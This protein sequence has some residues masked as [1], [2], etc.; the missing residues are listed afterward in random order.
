MSFPSL[1]VSYESTPQTVSYPSPSQEAI[2]GY[3]GS[4][5]D[6]A[7][8]S[9]STYYYNATGDIQQG[10]NKGNVLFDY[11]N[12]R[13]TMDTSI[14]IRNQ[15]QS[16]GTQYSNISAEEVTPLFDVTK[17]FAPIPGESGVW[18]GGY[19]AKQYSKWTPQ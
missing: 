19:T 2:Y 10:D 1:N 5:T 9:A 16:W 17:S 6:N 8:V 15:S 13:N 18:S 14:D 11:S 3:F 4:V 7:P 12:S